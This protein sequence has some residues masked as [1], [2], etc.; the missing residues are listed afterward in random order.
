MAWRNGVI[1]SADEASQHVIYYGSH[2]F[3]M[4]WDYVWCIIE[5]VTPSFEI[6]L[7]SQW[8]QS[9]Q[10]REWEKEREWMSD[11]IVRIAI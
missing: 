7:N 4:C 2:H 3:W 10:R 6:L 8:E 5:N 1:A 11:K 9:Q